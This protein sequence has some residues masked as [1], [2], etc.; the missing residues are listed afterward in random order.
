MEALAD[1]DA[2]LLKVRDHG[3]RRNLDQ[4][5]KAY[6][7]GA[8]RASIIS[9]WIAV[10]Y[11]IIEKVRELSAYGEGQ[12]RVHVED[13]ERKIQSK[14]ILG[15][16][17]FEESLLTIAESEFE[18]LSREQVIRLKRIKDDR[19]LCAH[20]AFTSSG[21]LFEPTPELT[22]SHIVHA[23]NDLLQ[24]GPVRGKS[25]LDAI[26]ADICADAFPVTS[27]AAA[28]FLT[29]KYLKYAKVSVFENLLKL[30]L[31]AATGKL[32][33]WPK[34]LRHASFALGAVALTRPKYFED[35]MGQN[36][37][38][39]ADSLN[40]D[41]IPRFFGLIGQDR[42]YW[43]WIGEHHRLQL[44][45]L[46]SRTT[47]IPGSGE[48]SRDPTS[49]WEAAGEVL[50]GLV[51]F[52]QETKFTKSTGLS[53]FTTLFELTDVDRLRP[54]LLILFSALDDNQKI[55]V[56]SKAPQPLFG[57]EAV[58]LYEGAASFRE[59]ERLGA[60]VVLP[61]APHFGIKQ[62]VSVFDA[63]LGNGQIYPAGGTDR[64]LSEFVAAL[65]ERSDLDIVSV[66]DWSSFIASL[67]EMYDHYDELSETLAKNGLV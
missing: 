52:T 37:P 64:I 29:E 18:L 58:S 42:R 48:P 59:A 39:F 45:T 46:L 43:D 30:L 25:S 24:H 7:G 62:L 54:I 50:S 10:A 66:L 44:E 23:V 32:E 57:E 53:S 65:S 49:G 4:A 8:Y 12:A 26:M 31:K 9:T 5:V 67:T 47:P 3:S 19:N 14:D 33:D 21:A 17:R 22:R 16:S 51:Q 15:L 63:V 36:L 11:D 6:H 55:T 2:L 60:K 61:M 28:I 56:V 1:L 20:P 41:Q 35:W 40:N 38:R 27:E 34:D 13:L